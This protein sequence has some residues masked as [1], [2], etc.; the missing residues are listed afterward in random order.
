MA[1]RVRV[2]Y[3]G[4][5]R[6]PH[7]QRW[8]SY[9]SEHFDLVVYSFENEKLPNVRTVILPRPT[10]TKLDYLL[11]RRRVAQMIAEQQPDLIHAHRISSYGLVGAYAAKRV[12]RRAAV[13]A[14]ESHAGTG[15]ADAAGTTETSSGDYPRPGV[16]AAV[17]FLLSVWGED[18]F[19]FPRKSPIHRA[20]TRRV[21]SAATQ[22]LS[23]SRIMAQETERYVSPKRPIEVTPF[24]VDTE[25]F[26]PR[27]AHE[28]AASERGDPAP[29]PASTERG[30]A[31]PETAPSEPA[32]RTPHAITVGTVKKLRARYGVDILIRAFAQARK[33]LPAYRLELAIVGEG[34]D[35]ERLEALAAELGVTEAV[36]FT[37]RVPHAQVPEVLTGFD[38]FAALS[39]TDDESFGVAMLEGSAAG[40]PVLAT[41]VG[42]IPE[43][44]EH[45]RTGYLVPPRDPSAAAERLVQ[46]AQDPELRLRMGNAGRKL[47]EKQYSWSATADRMREIYERVAAE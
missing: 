32:S 28:P 3:L 15:S 43:V 36:R 31:A 23:T 34:P 39:I 37:G 46:L 27:A 14:T 10:G 42:G 45:G 38:I 35:R 18:I 40:L 2:A 21:L 47:V 30:E 5:S 22:I 20:I 1:E 13:A 7:N 25:L 8:V 9:L 12:G 16:S 29:G 26:R 4:N 24:G 19:S 17:P 44:V 33:R 6:S 11:L 41:S